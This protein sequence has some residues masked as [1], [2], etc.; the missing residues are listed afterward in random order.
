MPLFA[1]VRTRATGWLPAAD[2]EDQPEWREHADFMTGLEAE[3]VVVLGGPLDGT[4]DVLLIMRAD[5]PEMIMA[6]L[7][8]D[9]WTSLNLLQV[10]SITRWTLRLGKTPDP[11]PAAPGLKD[12]P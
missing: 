6:R 1:V 7:D 8:G 9:P 5:S 10:R 4:P 3:G 12:V 11:P 2:L